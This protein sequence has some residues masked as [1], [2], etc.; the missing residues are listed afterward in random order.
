[1][2]GLGPRNQELLQKRDVLQAQIDD[3]HRHGK[4]RHTG[5]VQDAPRSERSAF[6][7]SA[8]YKHFL[9][10]IGYMLPPVSG[11]HEIETTGL[12]AEIS[13]GQPWSITRRGQNTAR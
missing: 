9:G 3:W 7:D 4:W 2:H 13:T 5:T 6:F 12:D 1:M 10:Q 8:E 11:G